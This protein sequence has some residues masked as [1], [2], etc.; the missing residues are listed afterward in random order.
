LFLD[1]AN[2]SSFVVASD[3]CRFIEPD[4][5]TARVVDADSDD[6]DDDSQCGLGEHV[7]RWV[8]QHHIPHAAVSDLLSLLHPYH[9]DLLLAAKTI[10]HTKSKIEIKIVSGGENYYFGLAHWVELLLDS[11]IH[12]YAGKCLTVHVNIDGIPL[13]HSSSACL[14]PILCSIREL[15]GSV[16]PVALYC[17]SHKPKSLEEYLH[18]FIQEMQS[19]T[20]FGFSHNGKMYNV[21]LGAIICDAPART[22]IKCVKGHGGYN[23]CERCIQHGE[24]LHG[25]IVLCDL[26]APLGTNACFVSMVNADHHVGISAFSELQCGMATD[27]PLDPMHLHESV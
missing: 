8:N 22:F 26:D 6:D 25:K 12:E 9:S 24:W 4:E 21:H 15:K 19:L 10:L 3:D 20:Q 11:G 5:W 17:S 2:S 23:C 13:Y 18:D 7:A 27:F 1:A 16:F 14:W